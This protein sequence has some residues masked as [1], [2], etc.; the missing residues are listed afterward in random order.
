MVGAI[1]A[2]LACEVFGRAILLARMPRALAAPVVDLFPWKE[3]ARAAA[4][5]A[6]AAVGMSFAQ[7]LVAGSGGGSTASVGRPIVGL[8]VCVV[9]YGV[10]YVAALL[11]V[12]ARTPFALL[13][14]KRE[15]IHQVLA[16]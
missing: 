6:L 2:W 7:A 8:A 13:G 16:R 9:S 14:L 1:A 15:A 5:A 3:L 12:G 4:A 10:G 11:L